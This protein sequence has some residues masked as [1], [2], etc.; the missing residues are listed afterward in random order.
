[1]PL[2]RE[3]SL[4]TE[5]RYR[6]EYQQRMEKTH[7]WDDIWCLVDYFDSPEEAEEELRKMEQ[8]DAETGEVG[9]YCYQVVKSVDHILLRVDPDKKLPTDDE[10]DEDD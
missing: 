7:D 8:T 9:L 1:M 4:S 3:L 6:L 10:D 2:C 5:T